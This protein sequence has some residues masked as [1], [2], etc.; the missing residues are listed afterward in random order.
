M[1]MIQNITFNDLPTLMAE[2]LQTVQYQSRQINELTS[3]I[4]SIQESKESAED[5]PVLG[6]FKHGEVI[7]PKDERLYPDIFLNRRVLMTKIKRTDEFRCPF[8]RVTGTWRINADTL[9]KWLNE[10]AKT[11]TK[12]V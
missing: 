9:E 6:K 2:L 4:I 1:E 3:R 10:N 7:T 12:R 11:K 8:S 5:S